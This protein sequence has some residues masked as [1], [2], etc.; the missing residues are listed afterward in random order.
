VSPGISL[1]LGP[2]K[3]PSTAPIY[4]VSFLGKRLPADLK[5]ILGLSGALCDFL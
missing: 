1:R 4:R 3:L 5:K 2:W